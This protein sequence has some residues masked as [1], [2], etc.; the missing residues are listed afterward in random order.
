MP[1]KPHIVHISAYYPPHLGGLERVAQETV[2]QLARDGYQTTVLTSR[3]GA[4][5]LV[6][7]PVSNLEVKR[8]FA[9]EFAHTPCMPTLLWHLL[10]VRSP[11]VF[12]LHLAQAYVPEMVW[13]ASKIR[14]VPYIVHFHLDVE[15]S[16]ALGFIFVLWKK[17]IQTRV[18][19]DAAHVI[20]LS[21]DQTTLVR[22]RYALPEER[23]TC[24]SNGVGAA[25]LAIGSAT[26]Q[27]HS[28]LRLLFVGR[29]SVQKRVDRLLS[30]LA[31]VTTPV[32]LCLVGD[33]EDRSTLERMVAERGLQNVT[34]RGALYGRDLLDAYRDADV[35]VIASEREG[36]PLVIL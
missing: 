9:F 31:H 13:L 28:P 27:P 24:I 7:P 26:R 11:K 5:G 4:K 29:F 17:W 12:H 8:L 19:K 14:K 34:F 1:T 36:M 18:M 30:A 33:G 3:I 21:P 25:F 32:E 6:P 22:E 20:T 23:V 10:R 15:P 35:F 2:E 16:G